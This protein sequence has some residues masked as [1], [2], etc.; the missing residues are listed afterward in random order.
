[1]YEYTIKHRSGESNSNADLLSRLPLPHT[2]HTTP[3]PSEVTLMLEQIDISPITV[4]QVCMW[5]C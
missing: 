4:S 2:P 1:M 3:V 5:T